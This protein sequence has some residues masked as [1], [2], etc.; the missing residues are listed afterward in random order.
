VDGNSKLSVGLVNAQMD[1]GLL[2]HPRVRVL[3]TYNELDAAWLPNVAPARSANLLV[4]PLFASF[5][6]RVAGIDDGGVTPGAGGWNVQWGDGFGA[7]AGYTALENTTTGPRLKIVITENPNHRPV[8]L[9][10]QLAV[11]ADAIGHYGVARWRIDGP[12]PAEVYTRSFA[13]QY[14]ARAMNG[15]TVARTPNPLGRNEQFVILLNNAMGTYYLSGVSM[16]VQ[17]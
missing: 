1:A 5:A 4:D 7:V 16:S 13:D 6:P 10:A 8:A 3:A 2:D 14:H 15:A 11:P 9:F 17:S 12:R